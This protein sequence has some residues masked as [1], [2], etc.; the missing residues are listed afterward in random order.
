MKHGLVLL[1]AV[2]LALPGVARPAVHQGE[3]DADFSGTWFRENAGTGG[4]SF[5]GT[6]LSGSVGYFLFDPL[7]IQAAALGIWTSG[8]PTT[9]WL[10]DQ[11]ERFY[12]FGG[13]AKWHFMP[14]SIWVP[15]VG[16]QI[17]WGK[18]HRDVPGSNDQFDTDLDGILW[19]P[20]A[21]LR[22]QLTPHVDFFVEYQYHIWAGQVSEAHFNDL[23]DPI[24][25][26]WED[27]HLVTLGL[28]YKF[29]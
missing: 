25:P 23:D 19:G 17:F 15:Y 26:N 8:K 7:E 12:A 13:K 3:I 1:S 5:D 16:G 14:H 6:F 27:G 29:L 4:Q 22:F 21:G 24:S 11:E 20:L 28:I 9:P 10:N 2:I 18:Y